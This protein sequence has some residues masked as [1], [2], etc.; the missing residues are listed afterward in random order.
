MTR[1]STPALYVLGRLGR[2]TPVSDPLRTLKALQRLQNQE[3]ESLPNEIARL[4][5]EAPESLF[6]A[7]PFPYSEEPTR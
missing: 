1:A 4:P 6:T 5:L 7:H 2:S 3:F